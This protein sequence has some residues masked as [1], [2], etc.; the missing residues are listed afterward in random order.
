L[1]REHGCCHRHIRKAGARVVCCLI[2]IW[3]VCGVVS[4][5]YV[6]CCVLCV[7]ARVL[8]VRAHLCG[9]VS[10]WACGRVHLVEPSRIYNY[11]AGRARH[12]A[13]TCAFD[14]PASGRA[15]P[16]HVL[17]KSFFCSFLRLSRRPPSESPSLRELKWES[18]H[19][20]VSVRARVSPGST[21]TRMRAAVVAARSKVALHERGR[22]AYSPSCCDPCASPWIATSANRLPSNAEHLQM[23]RASEQ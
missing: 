2:C 7:R 6:W 13:R 21:G 19:E 14:V 20:I 1:Q 23:N 12:D 3:C 17:F 22:G 5:W 4:V 18:T 11:V 9:W 15:K 8:C 10:V 16:V